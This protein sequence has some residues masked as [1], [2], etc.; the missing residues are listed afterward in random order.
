MYTPLW[1]K[2]KLKVILLSNYTY[3]QNIR[4]E[5]IKKTTKNLSQNSWC[6]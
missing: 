3:Y 6:L 4:L 2:G 5:E 1:R